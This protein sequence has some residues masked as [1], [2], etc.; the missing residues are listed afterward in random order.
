MISISLSLTSATRSRRKQ[1]C[2]WVRKYN[3]RII[4][5]QPLRPLPPLSATMS[6]LSHWKGN[7]NKT[8]KSPKKDASGA[9]NAPGTILEGSWT[10]MDA[11]ANGSS[12]P[13]YPQLGPT[14]AHTSAN[15]VTGQVFQLRLSRSGNN[16]H[17][18]SA[19]F[20]CPRGSHRVGSFLPSFARFPH[21]C[22]LPIRPTPPIRD[23]SSIRLI[24]QHHGCD[25]KWQIQC[26][27][28]P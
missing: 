21:S 2:G 24:R 28:R 19:G 17:M 25:G 5:R 13:T 22:L 11:D 20:G 26:T 27:F 12:P 4:G 9:I 8:Q 16:T 18:P 23:D 10:L 15:G 6:Y 1:K 7:P 14:R 3:N